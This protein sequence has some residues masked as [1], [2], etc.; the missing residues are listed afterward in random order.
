MFNKVHEHL[1]H[2]VKQFGAGIAKTVDNG[3]MIM[4]NMLVTMMNTSE[5]FNH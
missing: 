5:S 1:N 4:T 2:I 3:V